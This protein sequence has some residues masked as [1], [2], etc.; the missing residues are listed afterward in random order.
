[1]FWYL[2]QTIVSGIAMIPY[3]TPV[4]CCSARE[5]VCTKRRVVT[6]IAM[7]LCVAAVG[8]AQ[9]ATSQKRTTKQQVQHA[10]SS[11]PTP[12]TSNWKIYRNEKHGFELKYPEAWSVHMGTGTGEEII[13]IRKLPR[14]TEPD[15]SLT[16]AIQK[17][18]NPKKLSIDEWFAEHI[19]LLNASPEL[20][21][22]VTL[23][24][25]PAVFMENS[26]SF[27]KQRDTFLLLQETDVLS[28]S[29]KRQ[30]EFDRTYAAMLASFRVLK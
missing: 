30:A 29:H 12:D 16:L 18:Q 25:R 4:K 2:K 23:G 6:F 17:N 9:I 27:G 1:V 13:A 24:G 19:K 14:G 15:A 22:H 8:D 7:M 5:A 26:N 21:G 28:L 11:T 10:M 20:T 3:M